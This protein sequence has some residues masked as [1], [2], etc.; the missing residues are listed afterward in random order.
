M[1]NYNFYI[2]LKYINEPS[3]E[4]EDALYECGCDDA[5]LSFANGMAIL[6]FDRESKSLLDAI[7]SAIK[8]LI[9]CKVN[10]DNIGPGDVVNQAELARRFD[11]SREYI[12]KYFNKQIHDKS[13]PRPFS[14]GMD[15]SNVF[16]SYYEILH[17]FLNNTSQLPKF[18]RHLDEDDLKFSYLVR[19]YNNQLKGHEEYLTPSSRVGKIYKLL[20]KQNRRK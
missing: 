9:K 1:T 5:L 10:I 8:D 2:T 4:L 19:N 20:E 14:I 13:F 16:W 7:H 12:R 18:A 11:V 17:W 3:A 6:D 15:L